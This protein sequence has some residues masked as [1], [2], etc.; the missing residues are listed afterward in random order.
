MNETQ[1]KKTPTCMDRLREYLCFVS[2]CKK[3]SKLDFD[4]ESS[5]DHEHLNDR[6][7]ANI[8]VE[9]HNNLKKLPQFQKDILKDNENKLFSSFTIEQEA[10]L[11]NIDFTQK[12]INKNWPIFT[13]TS[14]STQPQLLL[15]KNALLNQNEC[16]IK[17]P[18]PNKLIM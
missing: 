7:S 3:K 4:L 5:I 6:I 17:K 13:N 16:Y 15:A 9:I 18:E 10:I 11:K 1:P 2:C 8:Y 14:T 12:N